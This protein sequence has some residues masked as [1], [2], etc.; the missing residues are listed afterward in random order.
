MEEK[1]QKLTKSKMLNLL[2]HL[3]MYSTSICPFSINDEFDRGYKA[4][5]CDVK[6]HIVEIISEHLRNS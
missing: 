4:G 5:Y 6:E 1:L 2:T 3:Y